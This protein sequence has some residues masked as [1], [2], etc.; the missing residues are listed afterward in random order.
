M[1]CAV[2]PFMPVSDFICEYCSCVIIREE[3]ALATQEAAEA[4]IE[5]HDKQ[6][7]KE[8]QRKIQVWHVGPHAV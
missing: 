4:R 8:E 7:K 2:T 1:T 3:T 5:E 6:L